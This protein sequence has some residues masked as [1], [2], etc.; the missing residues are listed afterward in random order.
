[1]IELIEEFSEQ[2]RTIEKERDER[3]E[4]ARK[5]LNEGGSAEIYDQEMKES[6]KIYDQKMGKLVGRAYEYE[7]E[8]KQERDKV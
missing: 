2:A 5:K 1:M 3:E 6:N 7:K 8:T 4:K